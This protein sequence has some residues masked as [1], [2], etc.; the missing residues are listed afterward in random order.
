MNFSLDQWFLISSILVGASKSSST[1]APLQ[2][3]RLIILGLRST[4]SETYVYMSHEHTLCTHMSD[5]CTSVLHQQPKLEKGKCSGAFPGAGLQPG[6][7]WVT[8]QGGRPHPSLGEGVLFRELGLLTTWDAVLR[9]ARCTHLPCLRAEGSPGSCCVCV[10]VCEL[11]EAEEWRGS[12]EPQED[13]DFH[14][15]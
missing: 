7:A 3:Y 2:N 11:R 12:Q 4:T 14:P 15:S 9:S 10:C 6:Q 1:H 5:V 13:T 8:R